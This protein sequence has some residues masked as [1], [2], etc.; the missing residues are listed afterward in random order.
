[1]RVNFVGNVCNTNYVNAKFLRARGVDARLF[2]RNDGDSQEQPSAEDPHLRDEL[3]AWCQPYTEADVGQGWSPSSE[4]ITRL[5]D[6]DLLHVQGCGVIL[7]HATGRPFVWHPHG[8]DVYGMPFHDYWW[9]QRPGDPD[10]LTPAPLMRRAIA[11]ASA[12]IIE[13]W[14]H[15]W[16]QGIRLLE[17]TGVWDRIES[18]IPLIIDVDKFSPG[19]SRSLEELLGSVP[20][21]HSHGDLVL[22]HP[23]RQF[24]TPT[25]P[26][27]YGNDLLY[28]ALANLKRRGLRFTLVVIEKGNADEAAAKQLIR[29]LEIEDRIAWIPAMPRH[30]LVDWYRSADMTITELFDGFGSAGTEAMACG[31]PLL[32]N[33]LT[34][35]SDPLFW[36]PRIS[37]P[38]IN[39]KTVEDIEQAIERFNDDREELKRI[40]ARCRT[41]IEEHRAGD[42]VSAQLLSLYERV[43]SAQPSRNR[44]ETPWKG[45]PVSADAAGIL[46]SAISLLDEV[47]RVEPEA[48]EQSLLAVTRELVAERQRN[49]HSRHSIK[50]LLQRLRE[51]GSRRTRMPRSLAAVAKRLGFR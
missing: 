48:I 13:L 6:C 38:L 16:S 23:T 30:R 47:D 40:G 43:L 51:E 49:L 9:S 44:V 45:A 25:A 42:V 15:C 34:E 50:L 17:H 21:G 31:A 14:S 2:Y 8:G 37:P 39:V 32:C 10:M 46:G 27:Y 41:W 19:P 11:Q 18:D 29:Q 33:F 7:A 22:F 5:A 12:I 3:P 1:M 24:L 4:L 28:R 35:S 26:V 20:A 36:K